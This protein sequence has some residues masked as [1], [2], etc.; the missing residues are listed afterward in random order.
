MRRLCREEGLAA[1]RTEP[2]LSLAADR[3]TATLPRGGGLRSTPAIQSSPTLSTQPDDRCD[4][5]SRRGGDERPGRAHHGAAGPGRRKNEGSRGCRTATPG[6]TGGEPV[7]ACSVVGAALPTDDL[8]VCA[9]SPAR[10]RRGA[11]GEI[12][13]REGP[14]LTSG[15]IP[16]RWGRGTWLLNDPS[17]DLRP[18]RS[19]RHAPAQS[20][21]HTHASEKHKTDRD[22]SGARPIDVP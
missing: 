6:A 22:S 13:P 15:S 16:Y 9:S 10:G 17:T 21:R 5:R 11:P 2:R 12:G 4:G 3:S 7:R 8:P 19:V 18:I 1:A 20:G 14:S